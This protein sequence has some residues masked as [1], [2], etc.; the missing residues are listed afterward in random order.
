MFN[1]KETRNQLPLFPFPLAVSYEKG[2]AEFERIERI[3]KFGEFE[4]VQPS[5]F[6]GFKFESVE[7]SSVAACIKRDRA[8]REEIA[9]YLLW[10]L[11]NLS[12]KLPVT[13]D[14]TPEARTSTSAQLW[15]N[16]DSK[17]ASEAGVKP[18][19]I[20]LIQGLDI[21]VFDYILGQIDRHSG[22]WMIN[23]NKD[24]TLIDNGYGFRRLNH[25]SFFVSAFQGR[26]LESN[27]FNFIE[28][29][30]GLPYGFGG[31]EE[32]QIADIKENA[33]DLK[34]VGYIYGEPVQLANEEF[35]P[36]SVKWCEGNFPSYIVRKCKCE[37]C[38]QKYELEREAKFEKRMD[39]LKRIRDMKEAA[40]SQ[41]RE[42][43]MLKR[44]GE[45]I[46]SKCARKS[47]RICGVERAQ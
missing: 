35:A 4:N 37:S 2:E 11:S 29:V 34:A 38:A 14:R 47:C 42:Y 44:R 23:S 13:V 25:N 31:L 33:A 28:I 40:E 12:F 30:L 15:T 5:E 8:S 19:N 16:D 36:E 9:S 45:R 41:V 32:N 17:E 22:N 7:D 24:V 43:E 39:D 46:R 18:E 6:H 1:E 27:H 20:D 10:K 26:K 3:L 21:A